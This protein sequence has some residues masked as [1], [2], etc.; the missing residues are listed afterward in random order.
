MKIALPVTGLIFGVLFATN[1]AYAAKPGYSEGDWVSFGPARTVNSIAIDDEKIYFA[2]SESGILRLDRFSE[3]WQDPLTTSDGLPSNNILHIAYDQSKRELWIDTNLGTGI[4]EATFQEFVSGGVFPFD[5]EKKNS[6]YRPGTLFTEFGYTYFPGYIL[7]IQGRR[8]NIT[9]TVVDNRYRAWFGI[10]G[11]G[12]AKVN[13]RSGDMEFIRFGPLSADQRA[14]TTDGDYLYM[15]G[16][17][18]PGQK[19]GISRMRLSSMEWVYYESP[20]EMGLQDAR[21]NCVD[22]DKEAVWFGTAAGLVRYDI[23]S[24]SFN[25]Y[26]VFNGLLSNYISAVAVDENYIWVGTDNGLNLIRYYYGKEDSLSFRK[27]P[28]EQSF[29]G[30]FIYDIEVDDLF[31]YVGSQ[32]GIFYRT[33]KSEYWQNYSPVT[34]GGGRDIT[35]VLSTKK[36]LWFGHPGEIIFFNPKDEIRRGFTPAGLSTAANINEIVSSKDKIFA[37]TDDGFVAIKTKTGESRLFN[38]DDGLI[39]S[40]VYSITVNDDYLWCATRGGLTRVYI[41]ALRIY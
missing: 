29:F 25:T 4:Y 41:P 13:T 37:A 28:R 19:N 17:P 2:T 31:I 16:Y 36:G 26:T 33:Q 20:Y 8:F 39:H 22:A 34:I 38:E 35:A 27:L 24:E 21:V 6:N 18:E 10:H 23:D 40:Q 14:I 9:R 12:P 1:S 30:Q 7:D 15:G 5:L 3:N 11:F 32:A